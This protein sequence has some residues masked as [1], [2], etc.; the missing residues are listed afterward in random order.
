[1]ELKPLPEHLRYAFLGPDSTYPIVVS[2][3]LS[4]REC[5]KLLCVLNKYRSAIGWSISDLKGISAT[6][7]MHRILLEEGHK[8]HVQN[9]RRLNPIMQDVVRKEVIK[10]LDAEIIYAISDSE[11]VSPTQVAAKKGRMTVVPGKDGE[12]IATRVATGWR[13]CIDYRMLNAAKRS[14]PFALY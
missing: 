3:S 13:V 10:L 14:L 5:E 1:M 8:P 4:D 2:V 7:C 6:T 12:M 9:Q 11:C